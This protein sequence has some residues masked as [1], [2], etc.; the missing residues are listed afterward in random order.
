M[1]ILTGLIAI[2]L[3]CSTAWC[4]DLAKN[5]DLLDSTLSSS[6]STVAPP[7]SS[8]NIENTTRQMLNGSDARPV[9]TSS[10]IPTQSIVEKAPETESVWKGK[11]STFKLTAQGVVGKKP[12]DANEPTAFYEHPLFWISGAIFGLSLIGFVGYLIY[13]TA[14]P[15]KAVRPIFHIVGETTT[16]IKAESPSV[17]KS[18]ATARKK[19]A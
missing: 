11:K 14:Q 19:A 10:A 18:P 15:K 5:A 2:A 4:G 13:K 16:G 8:T 3:L 17:G 9:E 1:K 6:T 7:V 12:V